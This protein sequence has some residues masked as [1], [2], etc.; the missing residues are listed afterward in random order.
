MI[1]VD[2]SLPTL[3]KIFKELELQLFWRGFHF[4]LYMIL[5]YY[6]KSY[7]HSLK[8]TFTLF[9]LNYFDINKINFCTMNKNIFFY[10]W[11]GSLSS[12]WIRSQQQFLKPAGTLSVT[13]NPGQSVLCKAWKL[14]YLPWCPPD[15]VTWHQ[16]RSILTQD[17][18][19][20]FYY[21]ASWL[22]VSLALLPKSSR[23]PAVWT[24]MVYL[25]THLP[26][27]ETSFRG[28]NAR[29]YPEKRENK[30]GRDTWSRDKKVAFVE[31]IPI[32]ARNFW[33]NSLPVLLVILRIVRN[34][35]FVGPCNTGK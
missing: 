1:R 33:L 25:E 4:E 34:V 13:R 23:D 8:R 27:S 21:H 32:L 16:V 19:A 14:A 12:R 2:F 26:M 17:R 18:I 3:V 5:E 7:N 10:S 22:P 24:T 35:V 30:K 6:K 15:L 28:P 31:V 20:V 9:I 29:L 11:I